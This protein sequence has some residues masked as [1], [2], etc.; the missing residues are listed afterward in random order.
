MSIQSSDA[1]DTPKPGKKRG[2]W[3]KLASGVTI[4]GLILGLGLLG[5][6]AL[7]VRTVNESLDS[8]Q[9]GNFVQA[10]EQ[11]RHALAMMSILPDAKSFAISL[12]LFSNMY[13]CRRLFQKAEVYNM[14]LMIF[15]RKHWGQESVEY[16]DAL[17]SLALIKRKVQQWAESEMM[18]KNAIASYAKHSGAEVEGAHAK[19]L[20]AWVQLK[21]N[22]IDDALTSIN[23]SDAV[24][25]A[26]FGEKHFER[27][28][29]LVELAVIHEKQGKNELL[30]S[31]VE[32]LYKMV[33]EP[34]LEASSAQTVV[35][36][37]LLAQYLVE[38][39][40]DEKALRVFEIAEA[41]CKNSVFGGENNLFMVDILEPHAKLL[42]KMGRKADALVLKKRAIEIRGIEL[43]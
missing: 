36:L 21:Q 14:R 32:S 18:Y 28:V 19:A 39:G 41:N 43:S 12:R 25:K 13:S 34:K 4:L 20:C 37:N 10:Q 8:I 11:A 16:A 2:R 23:E 35:V 7:W 22:K 15:D 33:T 29:G 1:K 30:R 38:F 17:A 42:E 9:A 5:R 27:L 40:E 24:L 6:Y 26:K 31:E 3:F